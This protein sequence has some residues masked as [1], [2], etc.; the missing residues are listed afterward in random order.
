M[1]LSMLFKKNNYLSEEF[2]IAK[3]Y[4]SLYQNRLSIE[5]KILVENFIAAERKTYLFKYLLLKKVFKN[6]WL[7]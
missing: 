6:Y 1:K 4:Y 3:K 7:E 2:S 5:N